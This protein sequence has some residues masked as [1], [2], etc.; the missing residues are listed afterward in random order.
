M[1]LTISHGDRVRG[2]HHVTPRG[3]RHTKQQL[4]DSPC[5][6]IDVHR[7]VFIAEGGELLPG[8]VRKLHTRVIEKAG[9]GPNGMCDLP[10]RSEARLTHAQQ[11]R[12][13]Y[14]VGL[15]R[16]RPHPYLLRARRGN[17]ESRVG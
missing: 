9:V 4:G 14:L 10:Q 7:L 5:N 8:E 15:D 16:D 1:L 3:P 12:D 11:S 6:A 2:M 13:I 17:R